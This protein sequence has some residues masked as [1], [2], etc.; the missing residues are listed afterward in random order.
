MN[1]TEKLKEII[2]S[3]GVR[4][5]LKFLNGLAGHRFSA[6][7]RFN[8]ENLE[9]VMLF[10][11]ENPELL[12]MPQIPIL[13]SYCVFVRDTERRFSVENSIQDERVENHQKRLEVISYIGVPLLDEDGKMFGTICHFDVVP[14]SASTQDIELMEQMSKLLQKQSSAI[15]FNPIL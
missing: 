8:N 14:R 10:D 6:I 9:S 15:S 5:A 3:K 13:A 7:Y 1:D 4:E 2:S 11:R 12:T